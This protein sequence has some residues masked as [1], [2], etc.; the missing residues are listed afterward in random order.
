MR[1]LLL[2]VGV[3][4]AGGIAAALSGRTER[5]AA[6]LGAG[7]A[8]AGTLVGL[9]AVI[10]ILVSG[11][12]DAVRMPW[13]L[14][15][16]SLHCEIDPLAA[17]FL[18]PL[19]VLSSA[20]AMYA[21][22]YLRGRGHGAVRF[23]WPCFNA[24]TA[25]MAI[26]FVAR[27]SVLF[28]IAW[29]IVAL[30]SFLLVTFDDGREDVRAAGRL[31][32]LAAHVGTAFLLAMFALLSARS[33]SLEFE[34]F[35][36]PGR[37]GAGHAVF[38]LAIVGFGS[39]AGW[40]PFHVWLPEAHP[41]APSP[42]SAVMSGTMVSLG[43]YGVLRV[44][45]FLGADPDARWGWTL[46]AVGI[47][48]AVLGAL[49]AVAQTDLK[50][51]LAYSTVENTGIMALGLGL[52]VLAYANHAPVAGRL[53]YAA[54]IL[55][56]LNHA[57]FKGLLFLGAGAVLHASGTT[58]LDRLGG[59]WRRMPRTGA[60]FLMGSMSAS[61]LP[62]TAGFASEFLLALAALLALSSPAAAPGGIVVLVALS[63][64]G[65][66]ALA[67][68]TRGFGMAFL[69]HPRKAQEHAARDPGPLMRFPMQILAVAGLLLGA[70]ELAC[71]NGWVS[72]M[73][74][75]IPGDGALPV[76][77]AAPVGTAIVLAA[78]LA[79]WVV[80]RAAGRRPAASVETWACGYAP[81]N[82]RMQYTA[83]SYSQ[84]ILSLAGRAIGVH[85]RLASPSGTFPAGA[86][87]E[88]I[89]ADPVLEVYAGA[90]RAA[91]RGLRELRWLQRGRVQ[92]YV[93]YI[94][95]TLLAAIA[96]VATALP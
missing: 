31:Y 1:L 57:L 48:S 60:A 71:I 8:V 2:A 54:V 93:L 45:S 16:A 74:A 34:S 63:A 58:E 15:G 25:S 9:F 66:L 44:L 79:V 56:V 26:V 3:L 39:K 10:P 19:F 32:L 11:R 35:L 52:G 70:I 51:V 61:S 81:T 91:G 88:T 73:G 72:R 6:L 94:A 68:A 20:S 41:V 83:A 33:G 65:G 22:S 17:W 49:G 46:L 90:V 76:P 28:L 47:L 4:V 29:E 92:V 53:A 77:I 37:G 30:V 12:A 96:W 89:V 67:A 80:R 55:H 14:P 24:L 18:V 59:L 69:G 27:N 86:S 21:V 62:P 23:F 50:R 40:F 5:R 75:A 38:A 43:I 36:A 82:A 42:V 84:P 95:V 7:G 87:L 85:R 78:F 13:S 64:A